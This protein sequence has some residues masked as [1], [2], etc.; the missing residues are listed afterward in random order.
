M[1]AGGK[2]VE[3]GSMTAGTANPSDR[4]WDENIIRIRGT[5]NITEKPAKGNLSF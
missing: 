5:V 4:G 2:Q 1:K 3:M